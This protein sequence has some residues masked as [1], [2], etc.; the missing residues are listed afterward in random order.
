MQSLVVFVDKSVGLGLPCI[1]DLAKFVFFLA[2]Q[3]AKLLT[4]ASTCVVIRRK[5]AFQLLDRLTLFLVFGLKFCNFA[6]QL[7]IRLATLHSPNSVALLMVARSGL[8][9]SQM[10]VADVLNLWESQHVSSTDYSSLD[11]T[12]FLLLQATELASTT[13]TIPM[14]QEGTA[15]PN[16]GSSLFI[17]A[18]TR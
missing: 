9:R 2:M 11:S 6:L 15:T 1:A 8:G 18:R 17:C 12:P 4:T 10:H 7:N 14:L 3:L 13:G 5:L 16:L